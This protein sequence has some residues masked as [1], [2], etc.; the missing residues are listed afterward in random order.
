VI[1]FS[2]NP[3]A[4]ARNIRYTLAQKQEGCAWL[5]QV[6]AKIWELTQLQGS[7]VQEFGRGAG[8]SK[9]PKSDDVCLFGIPLL[10]KERRSLW[11][12]WRK[13]LLGFM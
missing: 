1:I 7:T 5:P 12:F 2:F 13:L 4:D 11:R 6:Q 9:S 3:S 10:S 8:S